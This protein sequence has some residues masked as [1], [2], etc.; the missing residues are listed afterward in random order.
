M[1]SLWVPPTVHYLVDKHLGEQ[2]EGG[3]PV[4]WFPGELS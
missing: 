4:E 3:R 2:A 1:F